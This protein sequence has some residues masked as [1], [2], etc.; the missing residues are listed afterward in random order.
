MIN[1]FMWLRSLTGVAENLKQNR[2]LVSLCFETSQPQGITS[3]L[4]SI[5]MGILTSANNVNSITMTCTPTVKT[6]P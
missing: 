5:V 1:D 3:G 2:W 6:N 4:N